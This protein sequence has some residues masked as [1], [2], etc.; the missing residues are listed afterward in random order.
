MSDADIVSVDE[1][2]EQVKDEPAVPDAAG[3]S[4]A[5]PDLVPMVERLNEATLELRKALDRERA[6]YDELGKGTIRTN[7]NL[8]GSVQF[9]SFI[10]PAL[11]TPLMVVKEKPL[12]G[13]ITIV[14]HSDS[15]VYI[16]IQP[17]ITAGGLD[18]VAIVGPEAARVIRTRLALYAVASAVSNIDIQEEFD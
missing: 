18:T 2:A 15:S 16:G 10:L 3:T 11:G 5:Q 12:R 17:G 9:Q 8:S 4:F 6:F 1:H 13:D 14:N 7:T